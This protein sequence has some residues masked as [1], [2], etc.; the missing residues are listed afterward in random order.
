SLPFAAQDSASWGVSD[1]G[2]VI[3]G[4][5]NDRAFRWTN[6]GGLQ[7]L[8]QVPGQIAFNRA[9]DVTPDGS[10]I[11]GESRSPQGFDAFIWI[12]KTGLQSLTAILTQGGVDLTGW[13]LGGARGI[14]DNGRVIVGAGSNSQ[15]SQ[16]WVIII[17]EPP[18]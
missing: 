17:S 15:G 2:S 14:S 9:W 10:T 7:L 12:E 1:D 5:I 13:Q 6:G 16:A 18:T 4:N 11:V 8:G 3:V